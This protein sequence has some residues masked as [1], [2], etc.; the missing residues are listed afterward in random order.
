[1][2]INSFSNIKISGVA[3]AVPKRKMKNCEL[4][5]DNYNEMVKFVKVTGVEERR[6]STTL[7]T[8]DLCCRASEVLIEQLGWRSDEIDA[9]VFVSEARDYAIP[10]TSSLLQNRLQLRDETYCVD[11]TLGCSGWIYGLNYVCSLLTDGQLKKALLLTGGSKELDNAPLMQLFGHAGSATAI[12]YKEGADSINFNLGTDGSK[13]DTIIIPEGASRNPLNLNSWD[14]VYNEDGQPKNGL[15]V[16]LKGINVF[17][18]SVKEVPKSIVE[19]A[20][21]YSFDYRECDFM[22]LHQA[23]KII[24]E[25][26]INTLR[27][28]KEKC[29]FSLLKFG[30]TSSASIPLT[31][32]TNLKG[33]VEDKKTQFL[34]SGFGVGL[35]WGTVWFATDNLVI[36]DLLEMDELKF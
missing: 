35:S 36:P 31:M 3:A 13:Y 6:I 11:L 10:S 25:T 23:N 34:C 7:T 1:M 30:N 26:I 17:S 33:K 32:V 5:A 18:F 12:E 8:S 14:K 20:E 15:Q 16:T 27:I 2:S 28:P 21:T 24:N 4:G 9:V 22:V 19:L 29:P